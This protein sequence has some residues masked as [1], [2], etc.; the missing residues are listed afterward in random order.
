M[1]IRSRMKVEFVAVLLFL[2]ISLWHCNDCSDCE[3]LNFEPRAN[4]EFI[5]ADSISVLT[6]LDSITTAS[7]NVLSVEID[8][9]ESHLDDH[10]NLLDMVL[11]SLDSGLVEYIP[12]RDSLL[13]LI[14]VD[15]T[16]N[17][18]LTEIRDSL[19]DVSAEYNTILQV[20]ESGLVLIDS[21]INLS[22]NLGI[23][24][25][26][27]TNEYTFPLEMEPDNEVT[28]QTQYRFTIAG[29]DYELLLEYD[30]FETLDEKRNVYL[31]ITDIRAVQTSFDSVAISCPNETESCLDNETT[32]TC[33]F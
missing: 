11:D 21:V 23:A 10:R 18:V 12:V 4:F 2:S 19:D 29:V 33:Y 1:L 6:E 15:S 20:L 22:S 3:V 25:E 26:D 14:T 9:L 8:T 13:N 7:V 30:K 31:R 24:Y 17:A 32:I 5:N 16:Q 27:S 28:S